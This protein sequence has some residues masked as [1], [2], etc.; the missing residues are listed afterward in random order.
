M[1]SDVGLDQ[2]EDI[3]R[4]FKLPPQ[5]HIFAELKKVSP[6]MPKMASV[7]E[8]DPALSASI[9]KVVNSPAI[10]L[11]NKVS[12][13]GHAMSLLGIK[14]FMNII[15]AAFLKQT[16]N[17]YEDMEGLNNYWYSSNKVAI[18]MAAIARH[19]HFDKYAISSD[20]AYCVG[21]FHNVGVPMLMDK[22]PDYLAVLRPAYEQGAYSIVDVENH[23]FDTNHTVLGYYMI[24]G[25]GLPK[26]FSDVIK[27][28][29]NIDVIS[30]LESQPEKVAVLL[31]ALKMAELIS[32]EVEDF[33]GSRTNHEWAKI[34]QVVTGFMGMSSHD[35]FD[36]EDYVYD[37]IQEGIESI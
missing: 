23:C 1:E 29:H 25:W 7:V 32:G 31:A 34:S 35:F 13:I 15:N 21:L 10:G 37:A 11:S 5:P 24:K 20:E 14:S 17:T 26:T 36:L 2:A 27:L 9:L 3:L 30:D 18:A 12:A 6:D 28:H 22:H 4:G 16:L 33:S 8:H 19:L